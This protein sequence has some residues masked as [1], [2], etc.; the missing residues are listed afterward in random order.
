MKKRRITRDEYKL[1]CEKF[2]S[3]ISNC[4]NSASLV[5]ADG[6]AYIKAA[7]MSNLS[8]ITIEYLDYGFVIPT[9]KKNGGEQNEPRN[10]SH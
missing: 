7:G 2:Y 6:S 4:I 1:F 9:L 5:G 10:A 3:A 8:K